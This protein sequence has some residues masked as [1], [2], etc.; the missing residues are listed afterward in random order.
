MK[1]ENATLT[2][3]VIDVKD[4]PLGR[5]ASKIA[6]LLQGKD[7][8]TYSHQKSGDVKVIVKNIKSIKISGNKAEQKIYYHHAGRM[9]HL[10]ERKYKDVFGRKPDWVLWHAVRGM[11]PKNTLRSKRLKNLVI[12]A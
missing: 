1:K 2:E 9:G 5:V 6:V 4:Q 3:H 8:V 11:L 7:K 10:R 12:E